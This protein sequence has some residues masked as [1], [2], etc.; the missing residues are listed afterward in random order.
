MKNTVEYRYRTAVGTGT[1]QV[2]IYIFQNQL[3]SSTG[4]LLFLL[5]FPC[6]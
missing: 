3:K 1:V 6:L 5:A 4:T 2:P